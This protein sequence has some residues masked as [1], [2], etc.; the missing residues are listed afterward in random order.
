MA[1]I[2]DQARSI[3]LAALERPA[4]QWSGLLDEACGDNAD[5]R[6][7]ADQ[8]LDAHRA[9]GSID[10]GGPRDATVD[11]PPAAE[12]PGAAVGPYKLLEPIGEGG[13]GVVFMAEQTR[14]VRR[15]V[16]LKLI[17]P[18]MDTRQV[19]ARFEAER[20]A[21][22]IMDHPNIARVLDG[23]E[24]AGGRPYFVMELVRGVPVTEFCD[25]NRLGVRDRL[26]LFV[27]VCRAVQHAHQKGVIHRDLKPSNVLVTLHDGTPVV[28]VI[29]FGIAKALGQQLTDKTLFT[30]FAQMVGT[31]LYMSPEQAELS[32]L[33]ID[34]RSDVY[35]LGVLLYELLTGTT[36]LDKD[37]LRTAAYDESRRV[38]R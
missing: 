22:A 31:P 3:F 32:G 18:G 25:R 19:V 13:F 16:A 38:I 9:L 10:G 7:R 28:K 6:A 14:P 24:T 2:E 21:L 1:A 5:L 20:Q 26:G 12:R 33:D 4:D 29:D 34:T 35:S 11:D 8:L 17:K 23:G 27:D 30:N 15:K 36:P 37:R